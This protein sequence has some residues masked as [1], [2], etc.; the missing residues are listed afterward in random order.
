MPFTKCTTDLLTGTESQC[1]GQSKLHQVN[2]DMTE[3]HL[4]VILDLDAVDLH[5]RN[6]RLV[7]LLVMTDLRHRD[8]G[9]N[10]LRLQNVLDGKRMLQVILTLLKDQPHLSMVKLKLIPG[11]NTK[12]RKGKRHRAI[13]KSVYAFLPTRIKE[14]CQ[15][16][17]LVKVRISV[18]HVGICIVS[19]LL[20]YFFL[21]LQATE[22]KRNGRPSKIQTS[23]VA[24][25][26]SN[27]QVEK[28][29]EGAF[30]QGR[31]RYKVDY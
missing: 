24:T 21:F 14:T 17:R 28:K 13:R 9:M 27:I 18:P 6:A 8:H 26:V 30:K 10:A 12:S 15:I 16:P 19:F 20:F 25:Y 3:D 2:G 1:S 23:L 5:L 7:D 11:L 29:E 22:F 4:P 31:L